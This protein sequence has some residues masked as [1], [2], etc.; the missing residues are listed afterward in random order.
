MIYNLRTYI[1]YEDNQIVIKWDN[2][3]NKMV[4]LVRKEYTEPYDMKDGDVVYQGTGN[5]YVDE[6]NNGKIFYYKIFW[7]V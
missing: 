4:Y 7:E 1:G 3:F 2:P 6:I 5:F